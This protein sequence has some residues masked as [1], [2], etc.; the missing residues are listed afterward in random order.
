MKATVLAFVVAAMAVISSASVQA[1][2][3]LSN[4]SANGL[5]DTSGP[6][7]TDILANN[8][9]AAGFTTGAAALDLDWVSIVG[10]STDAGSR[11]V[12]IYS[13]NAGSP[14]TLVATSTGTAFPAGTKGVY[15]FN[16]SGANLAAA[17]SYWVLPE[18]GISWYLESNNDTPTAQNSSGYS[19]VGY[20]KSINSGSTWT[21]SVLAYTVGI[22][23]TPVAPVPEP[24]ITSL[25][26]VG[27]IAFMRRRMKK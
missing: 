8:L 21:N 7:N 23:A 5:T 6:T 20:K 14:G 17:T 13:D 2:V 27:G 10:F 26:C 3:V 25:V 9:L 15:Q 18:V 4:M 1:G 11:T 22:S 16:F 12:S 24:A 19:F